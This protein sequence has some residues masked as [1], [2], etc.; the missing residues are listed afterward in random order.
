MWPLTQGRQSPLFPGAVVAHRPLGESEIGGRERAGEAS[1]TVQPSLC[2][3]LLAAP[4]TAPSPCVAPTC[5]AEPAGHWS[6]LDCHPAPQS[7]EAP[8][9]GLEG[10]PPC[11]GARAEASGA[12]EMAPHPPRIPSSLPGPRISVP[13][14]GNSSWNPAVAQQISSVSAAPGCRFDPR[15]GLA[16]WVKGPPSL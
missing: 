6:P 9:L 3:G 7:P 12:V 13:T 10:R 4:S 14:E 5:P 16:L 8:L 2:P 1:G 15:P 11:R